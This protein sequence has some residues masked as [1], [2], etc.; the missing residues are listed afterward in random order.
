M[1]LFKEN[2]ETKKETNYDSIFYNIG[3]DY[4]FITG[5]LFLAEGTKE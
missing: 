1:L 5:I 4:I 2:I 3:I